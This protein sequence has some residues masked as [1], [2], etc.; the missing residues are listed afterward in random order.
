[1]K[2]KPY[3]LNEI[4]S[5]VRRRKQQKFKMHLKKNICAM[6][7]RLDTQVNLLKTFYILNKVK[8]LAAKKTVKVKVVKLKLHIQRKNQN[9]FV[10]IQH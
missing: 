4:Q 6:Y 7:N 5:I 9:Y 3:L 10:N 8:L 2:Q 1:M